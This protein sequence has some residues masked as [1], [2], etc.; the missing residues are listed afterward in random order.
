MTIALRG[1][2]TGLVTGAIALG[3]S[4]CGETASTGSFKGEDRNVAQTISNFQSDATST[5]KHKLCANDLASAIATRLKSAGGCEAA[6]TE[7]LKQL[8]SFGLTIQSIAVSG[9]SATARVKSTWSGKSRITTLSL[10][11]QG[12]RWKISGLPST[13]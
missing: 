9:N 6:V 11:K 8:D 4:A 13:Q 12:A 3:L 5:N 10:V 7:Q 2:A 1:L